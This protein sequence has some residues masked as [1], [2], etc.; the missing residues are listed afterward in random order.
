MSR[1]S[2]SKGKSRP[3]TEPGAGYF[4]QTH[5]PIHCLVFLLPLLVAY[6]AGLAVAHA[7]LPFAEPPKLVAVDLLLRFLAVFG[8]TGYHLPALAIVAIL[9]SWQVASKQPWQVQWPV[10]L[11]M[12][13]ESLLLALGLHAVKLGMDRAASAASALSAGV[14]S[15]VWFEQLILSLGAGIYE[16]LVFRLILISVLSLVLVDALRIPKEIA[17][18]AIIV[19]SSVGFAAMHYPPF[20]S[21]AFVAGQ[22]AF[23][24]LAGGFLASV[25]VLR[26]FAVAVGTHAF[27]DIVVFTATAV[28]AE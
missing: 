2:K 18:S 13:G 10:L 14:R 23:R 8:A 21:D 15:E 11:G 20:G 19:L 24:M 27:Y 12:T 16:E 25:F 3:R 1:A 7:T 26:G 22:F 4:Q 28:M 17:L 6:E 9:V 5:R